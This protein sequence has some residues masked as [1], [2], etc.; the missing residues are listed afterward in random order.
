MILNRAARMRFL[1]GDGCFRK[2]EYNFLMTLARLAPRYRMTL[3]P[4]S[5]FTNAFRPGFHVLVRQ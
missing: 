5:I 2:T 3:V 4:A 1:F